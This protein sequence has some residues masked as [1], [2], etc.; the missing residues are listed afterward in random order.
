MKANTHI[1]TS[2]KQTDRHINK[3]VECL[4]AYNKFIEIILLPPF[5]P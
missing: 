2:D 3:L 4:V 1:E 5:I